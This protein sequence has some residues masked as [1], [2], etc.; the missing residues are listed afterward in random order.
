MNLM[1]SLNWSLMLIS[2]FM[3]LCQASPPYKPCMI[4]VSFIPGFFT[5]KS[6]WVPSRTQGLFPTCLQMTC[7]TSGAANTASSLPEMRMRSSGTI[8]V[9]YLTWAAFVGPDYYMALYLKLWSYV[10]NYVASAKQ[11]WF[12]IFCLNSN[13]CNP[14]ATCEML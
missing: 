14:H 9:S 8:S 10:R 6:S 12:V 2:S 11:T 13:G 3:Q 1:L 7:S 5:G 4:L